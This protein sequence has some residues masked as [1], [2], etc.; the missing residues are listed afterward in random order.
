MLDDIESMESVLASS[1]SF[2]RR[3]DDAKPHD[4]VDLASL[5]QTACDIVSDLGGDVEYAGAAHVAT[6]ASRRLCC[7]R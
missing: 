7:A 5:F 6:T 3:V 1:L 2:V 4:A